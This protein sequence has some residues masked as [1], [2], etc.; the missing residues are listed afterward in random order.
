M[1]P[2]SVAPAG[3]FGHEASKI[4]TSVHIPYSIC[5][6]VWIDVIAVSDSV[7]FCVG[8]QSM[9]R[10]GMWKLVEYLQF[11][12]TTYFDSFVIHIIQKWSLRRPKIAHFRIYVAFLANF[13]AF[14]IL[15]VIIV[16]WILHAITYK[17]HVSHIKVPWFQISF[18]MNHWRS[19]FISHVLDSLGFCI[20]DYFEHVFFPFNAIQ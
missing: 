11:R 15:I 2:L 8:Y 5:F 10:P 16:Q 4:L 18:R 7:L 3:S 9:L 13:H 1:A 12:P 19:V 6:Y 20:C 14:V 17:E